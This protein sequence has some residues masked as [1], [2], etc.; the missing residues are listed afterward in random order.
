MLLEFWSACF[1]RINSYIGW[2]IARPVHV[3]DNRSNLCRTSF[4]EYPTIV[5][6]TIDEYASTCVHEKMCDS[7]AVYIYSY[8]YAYARCIRC[9]A[10]VW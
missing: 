6:H 9:I 2:H 10:Q 1:V 5:G 8:E 3:Q 4:D 7:G